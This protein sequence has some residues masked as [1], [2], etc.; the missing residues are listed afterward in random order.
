[1]L[2]QRKHYHDSN[3]LKAPVVAGIKLKR[4]SGD[5]KQKFSPKLIKTGQDEH[6]LSV[7]GSNVILHA[8]GGDVIFKVLSIPGRYCCHCGIK[9]TDDQTGEAARAHVAGEHAGKKSLDA[10]N[11]SG[12]RMQNYYDCELEANHG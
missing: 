1:M 10:E 9:L 4:I 3:G 8:E 6:W 7:A 11:L 2:L 12:Y 5:G